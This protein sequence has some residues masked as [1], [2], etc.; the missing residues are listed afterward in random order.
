[1]ACMG[2][3]GKKESPEAVLRRFFDYC[4]QDKINQAYKET[5]IGFQM[6]K[7]ERYFVARVYDLGFNKLDSL[8]IKNAETQKDVAVYTVNLQPYQKDKMQVTARVHHENGGWHVH[9][10][11]LVPSKPKEVAEEIFTVRP[12]TDDTKIA[13]RR[14]FTEPVAVE[15]PSE[16]ELQRMT[17]ETLLLFNDAIRRKDFRTFFA[18]TSDRWKTRGQDDDARQRDWKNRSNRLTLAALNLSFKGFLE[19]QVDFSK[20]QGAKMILDEPPR[21]SANGVLAIKGTF[22]AHVFIG[23]FPPKPHLMKFKLEY[24]YETTKWKLFG[25]TVDVEP[26]KTEN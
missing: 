12:R 6:E 2:G 9:E 17:E 20:I 13:V 8:E 3:C 22:D 7:S 18:S 10:M 25:I 14:G 4:Q 5:T 15:V 19:A 26:V 11:V 1:M 23:T 16:R 21:L 24:V